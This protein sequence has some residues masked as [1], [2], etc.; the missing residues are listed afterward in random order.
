MLLPSISWTIFAWTPRVKS[1]GR[2][3]MPDVVNAEIR[4][5]GGRYRSMEALVDMA[6]CE[7]SPDLRGEDP[8]TLYSKSGAPS[9]PR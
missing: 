1:E 4:Q 2:R 7:E 3:R 8:A 6:A 5:V 9:S